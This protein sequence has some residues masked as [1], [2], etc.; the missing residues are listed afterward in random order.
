MDEKNK[1]IYDYVTFT[2]KIHDVQGVIDLL[3]M[4]DV[5]FV[6]MDRG[7]NGYPYGLQFGSIKI[8]Y[9]GRD[10][11]GVCCDMS[12]QGCRTFETYG[13]GDFDALFDTILDNYSEDGAE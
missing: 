5:S 10:D 4:S 13:N 3:G 8:G 1:I 11:M 6:E 2:T 7:F 9:G 12:G